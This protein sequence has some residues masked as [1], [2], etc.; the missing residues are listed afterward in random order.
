MWL[1]A[2]CGTNHWPFQHGPVT[3]DS[4]TLTLDSLCCGPCYS[5]SLCSLGCEEG[6]LALSCAGG[7]SSAHAVQRTKE[8]PTPSCCFSLASV[9]TPE[10]PAISSQEV[11]SH[12]RLPGRH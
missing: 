8:P 10:M 1:E 3:V 9:S 7:G 6:T 5:S 11:K 2:S 12:P 4:H